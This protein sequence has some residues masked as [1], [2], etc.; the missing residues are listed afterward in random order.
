VP[1]A[2]APPLSE[3]SEVTAS[4]HLA[5]TAAH[6]NCK[7]LWALE[8]SFPERSFKACDAI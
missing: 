4:L 2:I 1:V 3:L 8:R 7:I 6:L 5:A